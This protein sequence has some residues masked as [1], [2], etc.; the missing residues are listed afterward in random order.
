MNNDE[1][2]LIIVYT[3]DGKG[4]STAAFGMALRAIGRGWKVAILQFIKGNWPTGEEKAFSLFPNQVLF[5]KL[6]IGFVTWHPK[7]PYEEHLKVAKKAIEEAKNVI[8]SNEYDLVI[9]DE[10]NNAVRFNLLKVEEV[11][12]LINAKPKRVNLVLTGRGAHEKIIEVA[13]LVTEMKS[14]KHPFERG[15]WA[16]PGIDY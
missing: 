10:I 3:G 9:L 14:I 12:D 15:E 11:L 16:R 8:C 13:D 1:R 6:G 5:K 7:K 2:G 4:K